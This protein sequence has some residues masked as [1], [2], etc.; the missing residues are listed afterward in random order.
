MKRVFLIFLLFVNGLA[1]FAQSPAGSIK[2]CVCTALTNE[3][4][5]DTVTVS[6]EGIKNRILKAKPDS[7]GCV[8]LQELAF[9]NYTIKVNAK[10]C[11]EEKIKG[12]I[13]KDDKPVF[14]DLLL[15]SS[16]I[17]LNIELIAYK[18]PLIQKTTDSWKTNVYKSR[19]EEAVVDSLY[20]IYRQEQKK[21]HDQLKKGTWQMTDSLRNKTITDLKSWYENMKK[22]LHYP[23]DAIDMGIDA[24]VYVGFETDEKGHI[25]NLILLRGSDPELA[26][27]LVHTLNKAPG[28]FPPKN[29]VGKPLWQKYILAVKYKLE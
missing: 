9:G 17:M 18:L 29:E 22:S 21:E 28:I 3:S 25:Q 24:K 8:L 16:T 20:K 23:Q 6:V 13:I 10:D 26:V 19:R 14:F 7:N 27:E 11:M 12:V 15:K 1:L 2:L 4:F 5:Q